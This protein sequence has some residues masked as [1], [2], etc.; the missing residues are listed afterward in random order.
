MNF[1]RPGV[2]DPI[3]AT[4]RRSARDVL[5]DLLILFPTVLLLMSEVSQLFDLGVSRWHMPSAIGLTVAIAFLMHRNVR[6]LADVCSLLVFLAIFGLSILLALLFVDQWYDSRAYHGPAAVVLAGGWSPYLDWSVCADANRYC[7]SSHIYLDHYAKAAWTLSAGLYAATSKL[8]ILKG[9]NFY[10]ICLA[11]VAA[12]H[13]G[14]RM[15]VTGGKTIV[16]L[17]VCIAANPVAMA[18]ITSNYIDGLFA[19]YL[20]IYVLQLLDFSLRSDRQALRRA[21]IILPV[22]L[23]IKLTAVV[24]VPIMTIALLTAYVWYQRRGWLKPGLCLGI[25]GVFCVVGV[26]FNPYVSNLLTR[27]EPFWPAYSFKTGVS[28]ISSQAAPEFLA[29]DRFSK[30]VISIFSVDDDAKGIRPRLVAPFTRLIP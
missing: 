23:N 12:Y 18:Q 1:P 29:K 11:G 4:Y 27:G 16:L 28:A 14:A 17:A 8:E 13:V 9:F 6:R 5:L 7:L 26:G 3:P 22:L 30:L 25:V 15:L 20:S 24:Y 2:T 21:L 19:S 10:L